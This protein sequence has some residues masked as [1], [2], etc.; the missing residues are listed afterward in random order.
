LAEAGKN[1]N[2]RRLSEERNKKELEH[3]RKE[4]LKKRGE[5]E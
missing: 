4:K 5:Q 3:G 2:K 1:C